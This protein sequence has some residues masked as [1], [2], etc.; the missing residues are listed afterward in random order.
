MNFLW[1]S[2]D[3]GTIIGLRNVFAVRTQEDQPTHIPLRMTWKETE[4][5]ENQTIRNEIEEET[6]QLL[7]RLKTKKVNYP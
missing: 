5:D 3:E 4:E 2:I 1:R 6:T 7:K